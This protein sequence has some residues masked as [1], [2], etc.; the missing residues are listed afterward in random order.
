[1]NNTYQSSSLGVGLFTSI[2]YL[3]C[4]TFLAQMLNHKKEKYICKFEFTI[5]QNLENPKKLRIIRDSCYGYIT[6]LDT[7][8]VTTFDE[9]GELTDFVTLEQLEY[10]KN[11]I[12]LQLN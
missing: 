2:S 6:A 1:M 9:L 5:L 10:Q 11:S 12:Q 8:D 3:A 7:N 4:M